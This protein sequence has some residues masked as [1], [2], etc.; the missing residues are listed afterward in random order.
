MDDVNKLWRHVT[1]YLKSSLAQLYLRS[2]S[3]AEE[4]AK[5]EQLSTSAQYALSF[6]LPYYTKFFLIAAYLASYNPAKADRRLYMK[7]HGKKKKIK[8][9]QQQKKQSEHLLGPKPF[10]VDRLLAIFYAILK[11]DVNLTAILLSQ[12]SSLVKL[13]LLTV[14]GDDRI[15]LPKYKCA[16]DFEFINTIA[17]NVKFNIRNY[18]Y[19]YM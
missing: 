18:L 10:A 15:D 9:Q 13:Q 4:A 2:S 19:E 8:K 17:R 5:S 1:P 7:N 6:E 3:C 14:V 16:V 11:E 12:M